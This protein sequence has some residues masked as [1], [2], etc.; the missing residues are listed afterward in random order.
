M[1]V[2]LGYRSNAEETDRVLNALSHVCRRRLLF[3]LYEEVN[4]GGAES[5]T[6]PDI[7][8]FE[9]EKRRTALY[10]SHLPKLEAFGY[11]EWNEAEETIRTGP[12]WKEIEP[13]LDLIHS[14]LYELPPSLRGNLSDSTETQ[15]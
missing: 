5:I 4:S 2:M 7:P 15:C 6:Y 13:L 3:E 11:V 10:H 9:A 12:R 14:H 8:L 1:E